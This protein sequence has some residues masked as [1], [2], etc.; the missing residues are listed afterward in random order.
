MGIFSDIKRLLWVKKAV[1]ESAAENGR[2]DRRLHHHLRR[3]LRHHRASR[4]YARRHSVLSALRARAVA[5]LL[6]GGG[7]RA[8]KSKA[9]ALLL[10]T[11][12]LSPKPSRLDRRDDHQ[13]LLALKR[14]HPSGAPGVTSSQDLDREHGAGSACHPGS[15][16][17]EPCWRSWRTR[18]TTSLRCS[19]A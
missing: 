5:S 19:W 12:S 4:D 8:K 16:G 18:G 17:A 2:D 13:D 3:A 15:R 7:S 9:E 14:L 10:V 11:H 6:A 1:A